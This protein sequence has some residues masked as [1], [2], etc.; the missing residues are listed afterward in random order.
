MYDTLGHIMN[1]VHNVRC[2]QEPASKIVPVKNSNFDYRVDLQRVLAFT[3]RYFREK[4]HWNTSF[5]LTIS[6]YVNKEGKV[7][8]AYLLLGVYVII[9]L[10]FV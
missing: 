7:V 9:I 8:Y 5:M 10:H 1:V 3:N 6:H 2:A 4:H